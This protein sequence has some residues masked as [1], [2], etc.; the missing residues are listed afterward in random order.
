MYLSLVS[1]QTL[2]ETPPIVLMSLQ[3]FCLQTNN[4]KLCIKVL[5]T[6]QFTYHINQIPDKTAM[7]YM[8]FGIVYLI[9][10]MV[11]MVF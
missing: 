8:V 5:Q 2:L 3:M 10:W 7:V 6:I 4:S 9:F 11:Y 1:D